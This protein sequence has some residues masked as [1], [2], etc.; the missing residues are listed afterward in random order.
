VE[1]E[2]I[3]ERSENIIKNEQA[4]KTKIPQVFSSTSVTRVIIVS[5]K[6]LSYIYLG[7][8][9]VVSVIVWERFSPDAVF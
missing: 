8:F 6:H 1:E 5:S 3:R 4:T 9:V 7:F 2:P